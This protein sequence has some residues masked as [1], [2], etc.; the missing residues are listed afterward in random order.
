LNVLTVE[1]ARAGRVRINS[2]SGRAVV[3]GRGGEEL[4][5]TDMCKV[6]DLRD[7]NGP[8]RP[9][10]LP[11]RLPTAGGR[12]TPAQWAQGWGPR[13]RE[14]YRNSVQVS[15]CVRTHPTKGI[16]L[17]N[18]TTQLNKGA[19]SLP[20]TSLA[21]GQATSTSDTQ[22]PSSGGRLSCVVETD[23]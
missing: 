20:V 18:Q 12:R 23:L 21:V 16:A 2:A 15:V 7:R 6:P 11:P 10:R 17:Y 4:P 13:P 5:S 22:T 19:P 14:D 3:I 9:D 1:L 8:T